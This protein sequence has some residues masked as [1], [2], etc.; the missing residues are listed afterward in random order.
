M[1]DEIKF[2]PKKRNFSMVS[3][4]ALENEE[5][6]LQAKG[7]YSIIQRYITIDN[8][9]LRK[10]VLVR[11]S[12]NGKTTFEKSW[13]EL[14]DKGYLKLYRMP[15]GERGKFTYE[16]ELLDNADI[17]TPDLQSL[18]R[19]RG[20][21]FDYGNDHT[22]P[23]ASYAQS[24]ACSKDNMLKGGSIIIN[25]KN[26]NY[27]NNTKLINQS[28]IDG[29]SDELENLRKKVYYQIIENK[30]IHYQFAGDKQY[31]T[32]AIHILTEWEK[33]YPKGFKDQFE[34]EIY[35]MLNEC[36]I[37]MVINIK[38]NEI[39]KGKNVSYIEVIEKVN[40]C[41][42]FDNSTVSIFFFVDEFIRKHKKILNCQEIKSVKSYMKSCIWSFLETYK[43]DFNL[44]V[45]RIL[46]NQ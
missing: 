11:L 34:Q 28:I 23:L 12:K 26:N 29:S 3:N 38:N 19:R 46:N 21:H 20:K 37:E 33:F 7:L 4:E 42:E 36:L 44:N 27:I 32:F 24:S 2:R 17:S 6:T 43:L 8:Y 39:Y 31:M 45:L 9:E 13:K 10:T 18:P 14:K 5:L 22:P 1:S 40:E 41:I 30:G 25:N 35:N 15:N 16:Y